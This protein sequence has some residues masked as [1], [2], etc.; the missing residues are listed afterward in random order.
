M[1][2]LDRIW[3]LQIAVILPYL[4][5]IYVTSRDSKGAR[6]GKPRILVSDSRVLPNT[7]T[8]QNSFDKIVY[9][10]KSC[11]LKIKKQKI[12]RLEWIV[13][14]K[15]PNERLRPSLHPGTNAD[16]TNQKFQLLSFFRS[17]RWP[18]CIIA[19]IDVNSKIESVIRVENY[20][21]EQL[22]CIF[23]SFNIIQ[24]REKG[25][26]IRTSWFSE[27]WKHRANAI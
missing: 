18:L 24:I 17:V 13:N 23:V 10:I 7:V 8:V 15:I 6:N 11:N 16:I 21:K 20:E 25:K 5:Q 22:N 9:Q 12:N 19:C 26:S 1:L 4:R 14:F 27:V 3:V 2:R